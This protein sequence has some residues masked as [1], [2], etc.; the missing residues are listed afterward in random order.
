[1][2]FRE[3]LKQT[4]AALWDSKLRSFLTMFGILWGITSVILL[5]GLGIGFSIQ[6]RHQLATIG[7]DIAIMFGGKTAMP[8]QGYAAGRDVTLSIDDAIA[9]RDLAP[10]IK[11]VSPEIRKT[12]NEVSQWNASDRAVRGVWPQYQSFR[13]L[14]VSE[15]RLMSRARRRRRA[16]ALSRQALHRPPHPD[17]R[18]PLHRHRCAPEETAERKL[19]LRP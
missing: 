1:M 14:T 15:G 16:S 13:S 11:T 10:L 8:F 4:L 17:R 19:R 2:P 7:T 6:Q 9:V 18:L 3:I 12:V 5:V